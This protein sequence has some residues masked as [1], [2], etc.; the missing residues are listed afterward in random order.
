MT[1]NT[2]PWEYEAHVTDEWQTDTMVVQVRQ[3]HRGHTAAIGQVLEDRDG[4]PV[5]TF[6][7]LPDNYDG[8]EHLVPTPGIRLP[9][10][11]AVKIAR[12]ILTDAGKDAD[13]VERLKAE[14]A[15]L[16]QGYNALDGDLAMAQANVAFL[17]TQVEH[18][19]RLVEAKDAHLE[20]E[21]RV[22]TLGLREAEREQAEA[23]VRLAQRLHPARW[24][25][26]D[27]FTQRVDF[28][29]E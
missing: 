6:R 16:Q 19:E 9:H 26:G 7:R 25:T 5:M 17:S 2:T 12:A 22:A 24:A 23:D 1:T 3:M 11:V 4:V 8:R 28:Q 14:L 18:L 21:A 15:T 27:T 10:D 20:R 29:A 13:E